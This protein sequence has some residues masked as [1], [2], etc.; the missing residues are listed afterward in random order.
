MH[1]KSSVH[2]EPGQHISEE[3]MRIEV[4]CKPRHT[5]HGSTDES[6]SQNGILGRMMQSRRV[7]KNAVL[8]MPH[9]ALGSVC[10]VGHFLN[11]GLQ[12]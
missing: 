11:V 3:K 2:T 7:T 10:V 8:M 4:D 5:A 12:I 6:Q 1:V 9:L